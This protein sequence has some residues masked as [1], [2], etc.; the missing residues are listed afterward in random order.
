MSE[1]PTKAVSPLRQRMLEDMRMRKL[2]DKTQIAYIRA[3]R[4][5]ARFLGRSPDTATA[6]DLRRFQ[7]HL[8]DVGMSPITI[9]ATITALKFFFETTLDR[10]ELGTKMQPVRVAHFA[11]RVQPRGGIAADRGDRE[12]EVPHGAVGGLRCRIARQRSRLAQGHRHGQRAHDAQ[13]RTGQRPQGPPRD[14]V[15]VAAGALARLVVVC[16]RARQ[17]PARGMAVSGPEPVNRWGLANSTVPFTPPPRPRTSTSVSRC[18][19]CAIV[20]L[21]ICSSKRRTS[22]SSRCCSDIRRSTP[23]PSTPMWR[24]RCCG[25][26]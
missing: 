5:L 11:G 16:A 17:D 2:S 20:S 7:L 12:L 26:W 18:I 9:N 14:A 24:P 22:A 15:A 21:P 19:P 25:K 13:H 3:V 6:E 4:R 10:P 8:V 23:P 1:E